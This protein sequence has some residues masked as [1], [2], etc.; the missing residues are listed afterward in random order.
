MKMPLR[1]APRKRK[2]AF[3]FKNL[4]AFSALYSVVMRT[5]SISAFSTEKMA[6]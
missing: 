2:I 1:Q 6:A 5:P 3:Y 4:A